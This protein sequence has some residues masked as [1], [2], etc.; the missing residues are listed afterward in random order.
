MRIG[1]F[2]NC[3]KPIVN[4]VVR[5]I[6]TFRE[7]LLRQGHE[8]FVF[9]P[10]ARDHEEEDPGV[11]RYRAIQVDRPVA[12][13][14]AISYSPSM[15]RLIPELDLDVIHSQHPVSLGSEAA[16]QARRCGIPLVFTYHTQYEAYAEYVPINERVVV[17]LTREVLRRYLRRCRRIVA[18]TDSVLKKVSIEYPEAAPRAARLPT[19]VDLGFFAHGEPTATRERY[20]LQSGFTFIVVSRLAREKGVMRLVEALPLVAKNRAE[21]RLLVV[22]GGPSRERLERRVQA[23]GLGDRV[24][25]TGMVPFDQVPNYLSAADAFSYASLADVQPLVMVEAMAAGLPVVAID[26]PASRDVVVDGENGLLASPNTRS[27]GEAMRRVVMDRA[28]RERLAAGA[29]STAAGYSLP[30][31]VRRLVGI[32]DEAI[33]ESRGA[34]G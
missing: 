2:S 30:E 12:F 10:E 1:I 33:R 26:T 16:R 15:D 24:L 19:P 5:S 8:V 21:V 28:L 22:G 23:L 3:Y 6:C 17:A 7:E 4:G 31:A 32:Y 20:G 11:Y 9:A 27:L 18:P 13:P 14:L 25:F 34:R 29:Q